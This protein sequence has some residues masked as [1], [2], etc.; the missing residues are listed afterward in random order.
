LGLLAVLGYSL[1]K[2]LP[3]VQGIFTQLVVYNSNK[4]SVSEIYSKLQGSKTNNINSQERNLFFDKK[5]KINNIKLSNISFSFNSKKIFQDL[6]LEILKGEKIGIIGPTG[7]GKSTLI[8]ILLGIL[9]PQNGKIYINDKDISHETLL[10]EMK[11]FVAIILV[12]IHINKVNKDNALDNL[13]RSSKD[14][15]FILSSSSS[16]NVSLALRFLVFNM[17]GMIMMIMINNEW[18]INRDIPFVPI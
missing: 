15:S 9:K 8:N 6:D 1:F 5:D 14:R 18:I 7:I 11:N 10:E 17:I 13:V 3:T 16:F 2:I 4:N 12:N